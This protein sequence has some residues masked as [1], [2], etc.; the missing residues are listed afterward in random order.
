LEWEVGG[1]GTF[2]V[3]GTMT[4][5][6]CTSIWYSTN[7]YISGAPKGRAPRICLPPFLED[8]PTYICGAW[9]CGAPLI[10]AICMV[11]SHFVRHGCGSLTPPARVLFGAHICMAHPLFG[12]PHIR[13]YLWRILYGAPCL[14]I[15]GAP[16]C[17]AP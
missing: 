13:W 7:I 14:L 17:S 8:G 4:Y 16:K 10:S 1:D 9:I 11:Y 6:W 5:P 12:A 2:M 15:H 3:V